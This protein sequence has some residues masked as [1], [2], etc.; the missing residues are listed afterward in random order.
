MG[1]KRLTLLLAFACL[2]SLLSVRVEGKDIV[3]GDE[4]N[5]KLGFNYTAWAETKTFKVGDTLVFNYGK[6]SHNVQSV[7]GAAFKDCSTGSDAV[8]FESG[9]DRVPLKTAGNMWFLCS[10]GKHCQNGMKFKITVLPA[11]TAQAA[12]SMSLAAFAFTV[13]I[14][15]WMAVFLL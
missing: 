9:E 13:V 14:L 5:W 7:S 3:V 6:G 8:S 1:A 2:T 4:N 10:V 15:A 11:E 12:P